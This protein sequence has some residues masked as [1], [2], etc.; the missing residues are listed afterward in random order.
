MLTPGSDQWQWHLRIPSSFFFF[1]HFNLKDWE[2][3][4]QRFPTFWFILQMSATLRAGPG[5]SSSTQ[6]SYLSGKKPGT[7]AIICLPGCVLAGTWNCKQKQDLK[8][9]TLIWGGSIP[10]GDLR[11]LASC[12]S[13]CVT[14]G[15]ILLS[16]PANFPLLSQHTFYVTSEQRKWYPS[17]TT[18]GLKGFMLRDYACSCVYS[19]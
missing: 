17:E 10:S 14:L 11:L 18:V 19:I 12:L 13:Y 6:V 16:V 9:G 15:P 2:A 3:R 8:P 5:W 4:D 7:W 1:G